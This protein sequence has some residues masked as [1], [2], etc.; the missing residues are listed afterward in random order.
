M[1]QTMDRFLMMTAVLPPRTLLWDGAS[2]VRTRAFASTD[3]S[4]AAAV[5]QLRADAAAAAQ[6]PLQT[7]TSKAEPPAGG[8][9]HD[10]VTYSSY[11]W[12]CTATCNKTL[13]TD[14]SKWASGAPSKSCNL[15][16]GLP[17]EGHDG[18]N[19]PAAALDR[20]HPLWT[21]GGPIFGPSPLW[22]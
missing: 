12:P 2:L 21:P 16:T 11:T 20:P 10:Y 5:A 13:F 19:D 22:H 1:K 14:C 6:L 15:S 8:D 18:Y 7:V 9:L 4:L 3:A 17:W